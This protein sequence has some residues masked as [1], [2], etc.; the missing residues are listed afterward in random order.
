MNYELLQIA[1]MQFPN[2][3]LEQLQC[4]IDLH[5]PTK[6]YREAWVQKC[7]EKQKIDFHDEAQR[8]LTK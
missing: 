4:I 3:T 6:E 8:I 2:R 1:E 5:K 7:I